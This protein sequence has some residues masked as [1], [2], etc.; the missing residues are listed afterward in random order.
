MRRLPGPARLAQGKNEVSTLQI[1]LDEPLSPELALVCP[2]LAER[3][4]RL[5]PD[6]GWLAPIVRAEVSPRRTP[7]EVI[8]P[9]LAVLLVTLTPFVLVLLFAG[10]HVHR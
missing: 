3:A 10:Q 7:L 4:R 5:L 1:A 8:G 6:P 9:A 2:E